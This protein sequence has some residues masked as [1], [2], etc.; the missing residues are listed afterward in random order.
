MV[1]AALIWGSCSR[2]STAM[3]AAGSLGSRAPQCTAWCCIFAL[4]SRTM[5]C[6]RPATSF[7]LYPKLLL[8]CSRPQTDSAC[9]AK[10]SGPIDDSVGADSVESAEA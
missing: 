10:W 1:C 5:P 2:A 3:V 8:A 9:P 6:K 4:A 7:E